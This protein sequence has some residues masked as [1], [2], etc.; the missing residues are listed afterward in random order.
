MRTLPGVQVAHPPAS[1]DPQ[2]FVAYST[3]PDIWM[4]HICH[5]Q[6]SIP[7]L[8]TVVLPNHLDDQLYS[9]VP[10]SRYQALLAEYEQMVS[11]HYSLHVG[12]GEM[13]LKDDP[14][15]ALT[16]SAVGA[17][18]AMD[19]VNSIH[20]KRIAFVSKTIP[21]FAIRRTPLSPRI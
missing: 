21:R 1:F 17:Q 11:R 18:M 2:L 8:P 5:I 16:Y 4:A 7:L 19:A 3:L 14:E 6:A 13:I 10:A 9:A 12:T 15:A 20:L